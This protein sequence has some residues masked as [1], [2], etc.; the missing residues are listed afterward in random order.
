MKVTIRQIENKNEEQVLIECVAINHEVERI[1]AFALAAGTLLT[2]VL[3]ERIYQ[4]PLSDVHYFEAVDERVFAYT[5]DKTYEL[6]TRL[7]ELEQAYSE[8]YFVRASK[9]FLINMLKLQSIRP[10]LNGRFTAEMKNGE[11]IIISRQYVPGF[12]NI[13]QGGKRK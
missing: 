4:V 6:K 5:K 3:E 11:E 13:V 7:Y 10:A 12:R 1:K 9:S 2:G 8:H